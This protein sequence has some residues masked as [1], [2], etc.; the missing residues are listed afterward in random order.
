MTR[1]RAA[2][3][4]RCPRATSPAPP[5]PAPAPAP[6]LLR[7]PPRPA[8]GAPP[9]RSPPHTAPARTSKKPSDHLLP[10]RSAKPVEHLAGR[11]NRRLNQLFKTYVLKRQGGELH[12]VAW[13]EQERR[14]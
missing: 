14:P 11:P 7:T 12:F 9:P 5:A 3:A 8:P 13:R 4:A 2:R 1:T 10:R 6:S